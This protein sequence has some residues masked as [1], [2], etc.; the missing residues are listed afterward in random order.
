[1]VKVQFQTKYLAMHNIID[2]INIDYDNNMEW[3]SA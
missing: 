3:K 1:M 2:I